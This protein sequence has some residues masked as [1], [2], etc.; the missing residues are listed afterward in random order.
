MSDLP[1]LLATSE[2]SV[3]AHSDE[4]AAGLTAEQLFN[5]YHAT[6]NSNL[7]TLRN[8]YI[9]SEQFGERLMALAKGMPSM[10][11]SY[12]LRCLNIIQQERLAIRWALHDIV[13][14]MSHWLG[15]PSSLLNTLSKAV[16]LPLFLMCGCCLTSN[17]GY[18][19]S[20]DKLQSTH[21]HQEVGGY[22]DSG[23][24]GRQ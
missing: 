2:D 11:I 13:G 18:N 12:H 15:R 21:S 5:D 1:S 22:I 7:A 19:P 4:R 14:P 8:A 6:L 9:E 3:S 17:L 10:Y 20:A 16:S 24:M 23:T